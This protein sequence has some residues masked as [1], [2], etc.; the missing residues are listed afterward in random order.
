MLLRL[1]ILAGKSRAS[2]DEAQPQ[3]EK[4]GGQSVS[5]LEH[6]LVPPGKDTRNGTSSSLAL[7]PALH[8]LFTTAPRAPLTPPRGAALLP[9]SPHMDTQGQQT[10]K[11]VRLLKRDTYTGFCWMNK[12]GTTRH[13]QQSTAEHPLHGLGIFSLPHYKPGQ[14]RTPSPTPL[15]PPPHIPHVCF[16]LPSP[17]LSSFSSASQSLITSLLLPHPPGP[18][19]SLLNLLSDLCLQPSILT[20]IPSR[21]LQVLSPKQVRAFCQFLTV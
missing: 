12:K 13:S 10:G 14:S 17:S 19:F 9:E 18:H 7:P 20:W 8:A 1:G 2:K 15:P 5:R 6:N 3:A 11:P 4:A 21:S 16:H